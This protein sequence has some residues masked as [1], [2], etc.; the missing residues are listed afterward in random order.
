LSD[1]L[2]SDDYTILVPED[3][4]FA[5]LGE[6]ALNDL[7]DPVNVKALENILKYHIIKEVIPSSSFVDREYVALNGKKFTVD[8]CNGLDFNGVPVGRS[9]DVLAYNGIMHTIAG[10]I[11]EDGSVITDS[12]VTPYHLRTE[13][14]TRIKSV[15]KPKT[16]PKPKPASKPKTKPVSKP[17]TKPAS[18]PRSKPRA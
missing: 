10:I 16:K 6:E 15:S 12:P 1:L 8:T 13:P 4:Y 5:A 18:K 11:S 9:T 17:K 7:K 2:D 14:T 3:E